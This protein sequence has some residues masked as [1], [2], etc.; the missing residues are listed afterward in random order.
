M[1]QC[2]IY[3]IQNN[4]NH[5]IYIGQ[6][7][8]IQRR[9]LE[10]KRKKDNCW[11]HLAIQKYGTENFTFSVIQECPP[12]KLDER[13]KY[14][15]KYYH[16]FGEKKGYNQNKGGKD[17]ALYNA[18]ENSK[19]KVIQYDLKGNKVAQFQS[20]REAERQT[21]IL[22]IAEVCRHERKQAGNFYW[23]YDGDI[24]KLNPIRKKSVI[25]LSLDES[26]V[27]NTFN[28]IVEA[29][30]AS[31]ANSTAIGAVCKGKRKTAGGFKWRYLY[32]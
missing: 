2:G 18:I 24:L 9:F 11:I 5:K 32:E 16:S 28:S 3:K 12:E 29:A 14:W 31:G 8:D 15:I 13:Q 10:H 27:L 6:S 4:I 26:Q 22:H 30:T 20:T 17:N 7:I 21:G 19:K 23:I 25:Q 1:I